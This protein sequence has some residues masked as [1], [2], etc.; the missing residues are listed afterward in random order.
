MSI[1]GFAT[2]R[3]KKSHPIHGKKGV[4]EKSFSVTEKGMN[5]KIEVKIDPVKKHVEE[6]KPEKESGKLIDRIKVSFKDDGYGPYFDDDKERGEARQKYRVTV[7]LNG[8]KF[9]FPYG[10]SIANTQEGKSPFNSKE[11][12]EEYKKS[13]LETVYSA[14]F[15]S[16]ENYP[17]YDDFASD[18]GYDADSRKGERIYRNVLKQSEGLH[19][20]FN[21]SEIEKIREELEF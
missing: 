5:D 1:K 19:R 4:D 18:F 13:I 17:T 14:Y 21:D 12:Y 6:K 9:T 8:K 7:E 3:N 10:D 15:D 20:V 2:N 11:E 16:K